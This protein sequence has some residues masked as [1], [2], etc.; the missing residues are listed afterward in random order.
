MSYSN[1]IIS[2]PVTID[3]VKAALGESSNDLATLCK[4]KNINIWSKY[5]PVSKKVNF[6]S[7]TITSDKNA[8]TAKDKNGWWIGNN[9]GL[10]D[11]AFNVNILN[12]FDDINN[13][14]I[15]E[16]IVPNGGY[17]SPFRLS[18]FIGYNSDDFDD[19]YNPIHFSGF[20]DTIYDDGAYHLSFYYGDEPNHIN[21]TIN[22]T[23][24]IN[25]VSAYSK[26]LYPAI[27]IYNKT[28]KQ[29]RYI[30][31]E[32][33]YKLN[34]NNVSY[35]DLFYEFYVD[36][37]NHKISGADNEYALGITINKNDE[38]YCIG[39]LA[40]NY[41][42]DEYFFYG[43]I[44]VP[45]LYNP[46]SN[47]YKPTIVKPIIVSNKSKPSYPT[48][49]TIT[50]SELNV[51]IGSFDRWIR[52][53]NNGIGIKANQYL[54]FKC[55]LKSSTVLNNAKFDISVNGIASFD[56]IYSSVDEYTIDVYDIINIGYIGNN[57]NVTISNDDNFTTKQY[58]SYN[59]ATADDNYSLDV[60]IPIVTSK[61]NNYAKKQKWSITLNITADNINHD[62]N[63]SYHV[64]NFVG[65]YVG[66][67]YMVLYDKEIIF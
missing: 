54:N 18:D 28:R 34:I 8:W 4:S 64:F 50:V 53:E 62:N 31:A 45:Y 65:D 35:A 48:Y 1:G 23:D 41:D 49:T 33:S 56:D 29:I 25:I 36:I 66:S 10:N 43:S 44:S 15:W 7:D 9:N 21:Q 22:V 40:N 2:A 47:M 16:Y 38:I 61:I 13:K 27:C 12:S 5:K 63:S 60:S 30:S 57:V 58:S 39:L 24:I 32:Q 42:I 3:D 59:D 17:N 26:D 37:K 67:N 14:A 55:K 46:N 11:S 20:P 51:T 6:V 52:D 19:Y